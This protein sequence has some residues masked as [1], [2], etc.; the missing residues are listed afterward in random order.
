MNYLIYIYI[1]WLYCEM[2][3]WHIWPC[4]CHWSAAFLP[5][6]SVPLG[7]S[8]SSLSSLDSPTDTV[9]SVM[10]TN[11]EWRD[12]FYS[13]GQFH[14][15]LW[16]LG[17]D[18][19]QPALLC[20]SCLFWSY[21]IYLILFVF[22]CSVCWFSQMYYIVCLIYLEILECRT[23]EPIGLCLRPLQA[24][25]CCRRLMHNASNSSWHPPATNNMFYM[26][27]FF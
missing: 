1:Y 11:A 15:E 9:I 6:W 16:N 25:T 10:P 7:E 22:I 19:P 24:C 8:F 20:M 27:L 2:P 21:L 5:N 26:I 12:G 3:I 23:M 13:Q 18:A 14:D 17:N 4:R